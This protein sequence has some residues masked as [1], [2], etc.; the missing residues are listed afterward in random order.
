MV[1]F[2]FSS[3]TF[4]ADSP[5]GGSSPEK[6]ACELDELV[7]T[8]CTAFSVADP[9]SGRLFGSFVS[10]RR[11]FTQS[12]VPRDPEILNSRYQIFGCVP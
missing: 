7:G 11:H 8:S 2:T 9:T 1:I 5:K 12:S 10:R 3:S 6:L 4:F